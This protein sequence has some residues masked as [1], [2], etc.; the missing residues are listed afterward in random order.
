MITGEKRLKPEVGDE[1]VFL[2]ARAL[3]THA[4]RLVVDD[5]V[6]Q[7]ITVSFPADLK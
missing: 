1:L 5:D 4:R 6:L 3:I 2:V 7:L